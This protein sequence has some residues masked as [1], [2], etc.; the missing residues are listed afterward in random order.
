MK[1][2]ARSGISRTV[3]LLY[4]TTTQ[5]YRAFSLGLSFFSHASVMAVVSR[6]WTEFGLFRLYVSG[7]NGSLVSLLS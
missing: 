3:G 6:D 5:Q 2:N 7:Q 1:S 4:S